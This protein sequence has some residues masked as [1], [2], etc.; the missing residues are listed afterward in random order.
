MFI[1]E[2]T[3]GYSAASSMKKVFGHTHLISS[4]LNSGMQ[5]A[6]CQNVIIVIDVII[7][8]GASE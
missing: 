7:A 3:F 4:C 2:S 8:S 1:T 5:I 6:I